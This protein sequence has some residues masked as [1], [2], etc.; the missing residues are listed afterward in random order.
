[1]TVTIR[2]V[3]SEEN[4]LYPQVFLDDTLYQKMLKYDK[5]DI[6]EGIDVDKTNKSR[7][8]IFC[9]YWYYLNK[10]FSYGPF[11]CDGCYN[12]VQKSTDFKNIAIVRVKKGHTEFILKILVNI[13][14]KS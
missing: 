3:I 7:E 12:I 6:T 1:M 13:K 10:N 14:Q 4:K 8:C 5:S 9:H 2:C 11:T